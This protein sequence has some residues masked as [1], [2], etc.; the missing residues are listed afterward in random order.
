MT[1]EIRR[2]RWLVATIALSAGGCSAGYLWRFAVAGGGVVLAT[3]LLLGALAAMFSAAWLHAGT[4]LLV[5][6]ST[7]LRVRL[8]SA[9]AGLPWDDVGRVEVAASGRLRD[10]HVRV[11]PADE[12]RALGVSR[13][14]R[15]E[16]R[17]NRRLYGAALA[18]P[19][20]LATRV[21]VDDIPGQLRALAGSRAEVIVP[22]EGPAQREPR[23]PTGPAA[24]PEATGPLTV[25]PLTG[26]VPADGPPA[27][28][29]RREE[30]TLAMRHEDIDG[31]LAL[32]AAPDP[33]L[34]DELPEIS[35]LR[36]G[37]SELD[38]AD[39]DSTAS[40]GGNVSLIIDA[41][42]DLSAQA[43]RKVRRPAP[44]R[45]E[46]ERSEPK[47]TPD[48]ETGNEVGEPLYLGAELR[49]AREDIGFT[50][51]DLAD[52]TRIRPFLIECMEAD[53][54]SPCGG[55][56]Y[57]RGHLRM[58]ARVLGIASEPLLETYDERFATSPV[59]LRDVFDVEAVPGATKMM[60]G[61]GAGASWG[62]L[63][64]A[65]V[66]L[67][68]I[69]GVAR[70]LA[71]DQN[72]TP[73]PSTTTTTNSVARIHLSSSVQ[74]AGVTPRVGHCQAVGCRLSE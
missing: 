74:L 68:L 20:G 26:L 62:G 33:A 39:S 22:V 63:I 12:P 58:L 10:G 35:E 19:Y 2:R 65:V 31:A 55:N 3:G 30:V 69:W 16:A 43:M 71:A 8:G 7:G 56:F 18:V 64:A 66:I 73:E 52:R 13:R 14:S 27:Q 44:E 25:A 57:A 24:P 32:S 45:T 41:T 28:L 11:V 54:F 51:E 49:R 59:S 70:F 50:V 60:R 37:A 67:V 42:T 53:D 72:P 46:P 29:A 4:P 9:W 40:V 38:G 47:H 1:V 21:S 17:W 6:D 61:G 15:L 5:A 48:S 36:R 34:T 23:V